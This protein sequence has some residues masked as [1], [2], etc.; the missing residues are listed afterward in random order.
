M[1]LIQAASIIFVIATAIILFAFS[2]SQTNVDTINTVD[3]KQV[4]ASSNTNDGSDIANRGPISS[5][6]CGSSRIESPFGAAS[7]DCS[8]IALK[9]GSVEESAAAMQTQLDA[10]NFALNSKPSDPGLLELIRKQTV[11]KAT[12]LASSPDVRSMSP[13]K[14]AVAAYDCLEEK[15][16][17]SVKQCAEVVALMNGK[18]AAIKKRVDSGDAE[19][20]YEYGEYLLLRASRVRNTVAANTGDLADHQHAV[21]LIRQSATAGFGPAVDRIKFLSL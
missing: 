11:E 9:N 15:L 3:H 17:E 8:A 7:G 13:D 20:T 1:R 12:E 10:R 2:H 6:P 18:V 21:A 14:L 5:A 19:A 4:F 16:V